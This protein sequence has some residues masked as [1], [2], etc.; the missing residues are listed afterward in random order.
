[1]ALLKNVAHN[2]RQDVLSAAR[3]S[4]SADVNVK[5]GEVNLNRCVLVLL[6]LTTL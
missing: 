5:R 2:A 1:M 3:L 4:S 6:A